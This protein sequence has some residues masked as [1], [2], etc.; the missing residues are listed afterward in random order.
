[1]IKAV[2]VA[3]KLSRKQ[4]SLEKDLYWRICVRHSWAILAESGYLIDYHKSISPHL[5]DFPILKQ[6]PI[7]RRL[8]V[9]NLLIVSTFNKKPED[10][11]YICR[12]VL[13]ARKAV[14][15]GKF[16]HYPDTND[17]VELCL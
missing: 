12:D 13:Y 4:K 10:K 16:I 3:D 15:E 7:L 17:T 6:I 8:C 11:A 2:R 1:M 9:G 14:Q 5:S